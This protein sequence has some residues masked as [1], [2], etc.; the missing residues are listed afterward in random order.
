MGVFLF[1]CLEASSFDTKHQMCPREP[2]SWCKY[3]ADKQNNTTTHKD[4]PG[5]PAAVR[6]PFKP[7]FT[8]LSNDELLKKM[9]GW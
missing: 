7:I 8:H 5:L 2:D 4:N 3:Q 6:E 9:F 1:H